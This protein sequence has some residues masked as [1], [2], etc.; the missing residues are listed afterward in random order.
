MD[1]L[2]AALRARH[3]LGKYAAF[4]VRWIGADAPAPEL[5]EALRAD[6]LHTQGE[7]GVAAVWADLRPPLADAGVEDIDAIVS[8]LAD[9]AARLEELD[10]DE[11]RATAS[12]AMKLGD[13]LKQL[14]RRLAGSQ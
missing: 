1:R 3:D 6:L 8:T 9:R 11:L 13:A 12:L 14:A 4:Q 7:R 2:E 5:R 10:E